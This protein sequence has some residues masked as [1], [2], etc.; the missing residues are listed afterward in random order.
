M[1]TQQVVFLSLLEHCYTIADESDHWRVARNFRDALVMA[2]G[3][4][5]EFANKLARGRDEEQTDKLE[6]ALR[7]GTA[8]PRLFFW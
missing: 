1:G 7:D 2:V 5:A 8:E 3:V 4:D 6:C